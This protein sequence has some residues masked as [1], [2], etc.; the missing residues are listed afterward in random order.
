MLREGGV[1]KVSTKWCY[2]AKA[3]LIRERMNRR[4]TVLCPW[5]LKVFD[6]IAFV[7]LEIVAQSSLLPSP[8]KCLEIKTIS[9]LNLFN[10]KCGAVMKMP[11]RHDCSISSFQFCVSIMQNGSNKLRRC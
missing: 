8:P 9:L 7:S 1:T 2:K 3:M 11:R 4:E 5:T 10:K 6:L